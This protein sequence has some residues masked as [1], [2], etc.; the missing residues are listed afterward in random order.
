M[1]SNDSR[2]SK[3]AIDAGIAERQVA[4]AERLGKLVGELLRRDLDE[5]APH[6]G[7]A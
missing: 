6:G 3:M 4:K 5:L 1:P 7:T 2:F